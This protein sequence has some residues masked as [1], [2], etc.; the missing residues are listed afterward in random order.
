MLEPDRFQLQS[1]LDTKQLKGID[2]LRRIDHRAAI[3][4]GVHCAIIISEFLQS[5]QWELPYH[6]EQDAHEAGEDC[7]KIVGTKE[8]GMGTSAFSIF[9]SRS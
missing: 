6:M 2:A 3:N 9:G 8:K 5:K 7:S 4:G 1:V